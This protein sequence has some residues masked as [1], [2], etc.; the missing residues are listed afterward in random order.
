[1]GTMRLISP[2]PRS[3]QRWAVPSDTGLDDVCR[4]WALAQLQLRLQREATLRRRL[5]SALRDA[6]AE[7]ERTGAELVALQERERLAR[8]QAQHDGLTSL[9]NRSLFIARMGQALQ[10]S[11]PQHQAFGVLYLDL[12][13]FKRIN[14]DHGH[15]VGDEL[16]NIVGVRLTRAV[17]AGD[18]VGRLGGDEFACLPAQGLTVEQMSRLACH[19]FDAISAPLRLGHLLF[20]VRPSIGVAMCPNDASTVEALL[21]CADSAMYQAKR[22]QSGYAFYDR[23]VCRAAD[24]QARLSA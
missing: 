22:R 12:D 8:H 20:A 1:M 5:D 11:L 16:L 15:R 23:S 9:P 21:D 18:L 6:R 17:R 2:P 10:R 19:L 4:E 24:R 14:D 7:L 3:T 13:G